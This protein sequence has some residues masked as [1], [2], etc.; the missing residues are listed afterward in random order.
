MIGYSHGYNP[1]PEPFLSIEQCQIHPLR[2]RLTI[3][4]ML[5]YIKF[6][7]NLSFDIRLT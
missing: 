3:R 5:L 2:Y 7:M 1:L 6:D 4:H